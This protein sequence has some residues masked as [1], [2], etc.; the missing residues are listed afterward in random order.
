GGVTVWR[1][2][3]GCA[4][5]ES[6]P[7]EDVGDPAVGLTGSCCA[8]DLCNGPATP[9]KTF[10]APHLPRLQLLPQGHAPTAQPRTTNM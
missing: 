2:V 4:W 7:P 1:E 6:C 9:N 5:N 10:F 3:R 8:G